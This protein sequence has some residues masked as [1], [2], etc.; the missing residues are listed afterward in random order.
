MKQQNCDFFLNKKIRYLKVKV[1]HWTRKYILL[2]IFIGK[3]TDKETAA[4]SKYN[5]LLMLYD[6]NPTNA[7]EP[8]KGKN[9]NLQRL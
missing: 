3:K 7:V 6:V 9:Q 5:Q 1:Q 4:V 2:T 8:Q